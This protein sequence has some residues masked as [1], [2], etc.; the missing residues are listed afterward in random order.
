VDRVE[1]RCVETYRKSRAYARCG[2]KS[3]DES[4]ESRSAYVGR[5]CIRKKVRKPGG[6]GIR[7]RS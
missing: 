5:G 1:A 2:R 3:Y 6:K 4:M 7:I